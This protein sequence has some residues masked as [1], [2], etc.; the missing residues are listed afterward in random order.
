MNDELIDALSSLVIKLLQE[1]Y[2][3]DLWEYTNLTNLEKGKIIGDSIL[4]RLIE[5]ID[6]KLN[7]ISFSDTITSLKKMGFQQVIF[8]KIP[9][10][11][12]LPIEFSPDFTI[13]YHHDY[14]ILCSIHKKEENTFRIRCV[15]PHFEEPLVFDG[16]FNFRTSFESS[17]EIG[18]KLFTTH[19]LQMINLDDLPLL[20]PFEATYYQPSEEEFNRFCDT[21]QL[22]GFQMDY[23][24]KLEILKADYL[25]HL[26]YL[27]EERK[28]IITLRLSQ[29]PEEFQH[30]VNLSEEKQ[31][32]I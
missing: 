24:Q 26:K 21:H 31:K 11:D 5:N 28:R 32:K 14:L 9:M 25:E 19:Q 18:Q 16:Y 22:S 17:G 29:F 7:F 3:N 4:E 1:K 2:G 13:M 8:S 23:P 12:R 27:K 30:W 15:S 6:Q 10:A 20:G